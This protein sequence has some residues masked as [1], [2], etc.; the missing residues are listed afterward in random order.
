MLLRLGADE[1]TQ[2]LSAPLYWAD[3]LN[4]LGVSILIDRRGLPLAEAS[5]TASRVR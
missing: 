1:V 3:Y 4:L 2:P 5:P